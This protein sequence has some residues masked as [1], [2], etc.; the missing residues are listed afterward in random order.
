MLTEL[1]RLA[2][3]YAG[4]WRFITGPMP[5]TPHRHPERP[6][7]ILAIVAF[8]ILVAHLILHGAQLRSLRDRIERLEHPTPA[9]LGAQVRRDP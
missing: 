8:L 4:K 3:R 2:M 9:P 7:L 1:D 5:M 6:W